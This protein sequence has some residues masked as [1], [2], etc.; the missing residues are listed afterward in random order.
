M[1]AFEEY[2]EAMVGSSEEVQEVEQPFEKNQ[3]TSHLEELILGTDRLGPGFGWCVNRLRE[4]AAEVESSDV[5]RPDELDRTL[6][7]IAS[8][9]SV[10]LEKE[11]DGEILKSLRKDARASLRIY[12]KRLSKEIYDKLLRSYLERRIRE[13]WNLPEFSLFSLG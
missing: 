8:A 3:L 12:R 9:L 11:V 10:E 1:E 5:L 7:E 2:S 13:E 6:A 4:V